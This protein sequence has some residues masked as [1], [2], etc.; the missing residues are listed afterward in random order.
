MEEKMKMSNRTYPNEQLLKDANWLHEHIN[1]ENLVILD[2]RVSGYD[3]GHI[4][5]SIS[6]PP[7]DL[8]DFKN[9]IAGFILNEEEF[10]TLIQS[11]GIN[12]NSIVLVY[13]DGHILNAARIFYALEYYG[14][15]DQVR[16]LHGGYPAWL[17]EGYAV[18]TE[19]HDVEQG[20]FKA[21][22]NKNLVST[23]QDIEQNLYAE[24]YAILD[25][26]SLDEYK[27]IDI[28]NNKNGGH[29]PGAVRLEWSEA[30]TKDK[31]RIRI[32]GFEELK[33]KF[34]Q[35]G[36]TEHKTIVPYCQSN[37][38]ASNTYF[39]LRLLGYPDIRSYEGSW[40]EWGNAKEIAIEV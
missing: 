2:A 24:N 22:A 25:V 21:K 40:S 36:I 16:I 15:K 11:V 9:E 26:R 8:V 5:R 33:S 12:Q 29:I 18:T 14:L 23:Q 19:V 7:S 3:E 27:G 30:I 6:L 20:N 1:D 32:L 28:R 37:V 10:T 39:I 34:L 35:N 38:R 4:P 31:D 13:D 17:Q